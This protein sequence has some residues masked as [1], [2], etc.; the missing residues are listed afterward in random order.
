MLIIHFSREYVPFTTYAQPLMRDI[1]DSIGHK[2]NGS[3]SVCHP[4]SC[5]RQ[6]DPPR[7]AETYICRFKGCKTLER[8]QGSAWI[9]EDMA[10]HA[11][12]TEGH[13]AGN[14]LL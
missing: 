9:V 10:A 1:G 4:Q 14:R 3:S 12:I 6:I 8:K 7:Q 5:S 2:V 11:E 13:D